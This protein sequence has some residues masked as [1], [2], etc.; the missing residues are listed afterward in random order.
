MTEASSNDSSLTPKLAEQALKANENIRKT[1]Y[2]EDVI[3]SICEFYG[4]KATQLKGSKRD[5]KLVRARQACMYVLKKETR[6]TFAEIGNLLGGRDH[7]TIMHGVDK[8]DGL[9]TA[10]KLTEEALGIKEFNLK[11][12]VDN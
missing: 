7:T 10:H 6:L 3:S 5:A 4:I 11:K 12:S 1:L 8:I 2:P 9:L